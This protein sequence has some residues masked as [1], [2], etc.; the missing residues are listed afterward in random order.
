MVVL[1]SQRRP[2]AHTLACASCRLLA[3]K[4]SLQQQVGQLRAAAENERR[5]QQ[6]YEATVASY[7]QDRGLR[8]QELDR[9]DQVGSS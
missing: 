6:Q 3:Q 5:V 7:M 9:A 4:Q 1:Q 8:T 2:L